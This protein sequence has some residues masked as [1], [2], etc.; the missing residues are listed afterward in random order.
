M[1]GELLR[2]GGVGG[3]MP[4]LARLALAVCLLCS[5]LFWLGERVGVRRCMRA[6]GGC[7]CVRVVF[8]ARV[9]LGGVGRVMFPGFGPHV[10]HVF[11]V[12]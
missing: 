2:V 9:R 8:R 7:F 5:V 6:A 3:C 10:P 11:L 12:S 1:G 4:A